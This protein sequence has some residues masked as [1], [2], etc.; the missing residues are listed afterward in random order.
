MKNISKVL[1]F[2]SVIVFIIA[3][4]TKGYSTSRFT[5]IILGIIISIIGLVSNKKR[6]ILTL[7]MYTLAWIIG[8]FLIDFG[9]VY[10]LNFKPIF[11][12][13]TES[14]NNFKTYNS[15][16]YREFECK[17]RTYIDL[18]Y[19][20]SNYCDSKLLEEK[21]INVLSSDIINNFEEYKNKFYIFDAKVS[22]KE[23]NNKID[24]K[25]Y[26]VN[27]D[28]SINGLVTFNDNIIYKCNFFDTKNIDDI[29]V[30]DNIKV[31]GRITSIK[32]EDELYTINVKDAYVLNIKDYSKFSI[33]V[34]DNK[35]CD[36]DK[37]KYVE[38]KENKYYTS[39]LSNIYVVYNNDVYDL[40]YALKDEKIV[41]EDLLKSYKNKQDK[42]LED[43]KYTLYEFE[44]Y[45]IL[46]C[47]DNVIIG[48]KKLTL[49]NNYCDVDD[50][51]ENDL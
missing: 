8:L 3:F 40:S 14:S 17:N 20:K 24:L 43:K 39:C 25:S 7:T 19:S 38:T 36:K 5:M 21:D 50:G 49:E 23:G 12:T 16:L 37:S 47:N 51:I 22:Y 46:L 13:Y 31:V 4:I 15:F 48:N 32:K 34:I 44:K 28:D 27:D 30:Y 1:N 42:E 9:C 11:A 29:K 35:K 10:F 18:L 6:N 45:N 2:V 33:N 41:L 26:T